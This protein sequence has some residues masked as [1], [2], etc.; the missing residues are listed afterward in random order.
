[1]HT[2]MVGKN[3][4][5]SDTLKTR[6]NKQLGKL[7]KFLKDDT[8]VHVK[9]S[10]ARGNRNTAEITILFDGTILRAE[11]TTGDMYGSIDKAAD[12]IE[13]QIR[14]HRTK[15]EKRL[16]AG[17]FEADFLAE[18]EVEEPSSEVENGIVRV[19]HFTLNPMT[20]EDAISQMDMLGHSFFLFLNEESGGAN[21]VYRRQDGNY[22]L[23]SPDNV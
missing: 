4:E 19:K 6:I 12:I 13:R 17:A 2:I 18:R 7:D 21:V 23:L 11:E 20:V 1:M 3:F 14:R 5:I 16:R 15:L 8:E 22:G 10:Q 9:L